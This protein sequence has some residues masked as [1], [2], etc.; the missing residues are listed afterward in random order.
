MFTA[1]FYCLSFHD[2]A[3]QSVEISQINTLTLECLLPNSVKN[4][5]Q[6]LNV[7]YSKLSHNNH[8]KNVR[9]KRGLPSEILF[10]DAEHTN[11]LPE[12]CSVHTQVTQIPLNKYTCQICYFFILTMIPWK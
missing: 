11:N 10:L 12:N 8:F 2:P 3:D 6:L 1:I 4:I 5:E 9:G 7:S